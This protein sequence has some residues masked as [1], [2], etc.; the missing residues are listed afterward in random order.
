MFD[1]DHENRTNSKDIRR[2]GII[3]FIFFGLLCFIGVWRHKP[4]PIY[5]FGTLSILGLG[6]ILMPCQL[7]PVYSTWLKTSHFIGKIITSL[8]LILA[9][10]IIITPAG[11]LKRIFSGSPL[12][13]V[14]DKEAGS[15]WIK[16]P[17][18][19][20]PKERFIKRY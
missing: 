8:M 11:L 4:V 1:Q 16:R 6:F 13:L 17:E 2:F 10:Y 5:L 12:P 19:I 7:K 15:Y 9:Y 14:P 3:A 18:P 20:Q